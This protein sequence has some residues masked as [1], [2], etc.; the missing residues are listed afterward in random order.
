MGISDML[1]ACDILH[2]SHSHLF[3][4][5]KILKKTAQIFKLFLTQLSSSYYYFVSFIS[6]ILYSDVIIYECYCLLEAT[7]CNLVGVQT[8]RRNLHHTNITF[9]MTGVRY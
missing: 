2:R 8:F 4:S 6:R 9:I 7:P 3:N 5:H 1:H